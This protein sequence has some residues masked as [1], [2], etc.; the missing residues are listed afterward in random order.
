MTN[1]LTLRL[2]AESQAHFN[3]LRRRHFPQERNHIPAHLTLFHT[4]PDE[5]DLV[6]VLQSEAE[7]QETFAL[8]VAGMRSLGKG[9][10]YKLESTALLAL[11]ARLSEAF[12][13]SLTPQDKQRLQPHIVV[14]NKVTVELAR[15]L[16][17]KLQQTFVPM[18]VQAV[19]MDLW[20]YMGGPWELA[21]TFPFVATL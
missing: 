9:L 5:A 19:G 3:T 16:L 15:A 12:A 14:Q 13:E 21:R 4:L 17:I 10:A 11:H 8:A 7:V 2:D 6:Q 20:H 1:V 18:E